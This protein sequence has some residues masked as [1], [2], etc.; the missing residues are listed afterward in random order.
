MFSPVAVLTQVQGRESGG[1][2]GGGGG[3]K[4]K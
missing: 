2:G 1:G 4:K 3:Y